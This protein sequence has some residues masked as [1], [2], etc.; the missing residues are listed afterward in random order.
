MNEISLPVEKETIEF[1]KCK[2]H[3]LQQLELADSN[4]GSLPLEIEILIGTQ[5]Y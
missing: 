2:Y 1:V 5:D 4:P 3:H